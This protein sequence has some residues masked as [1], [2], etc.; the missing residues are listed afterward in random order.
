MQVTLMRIVRSIAIIQEVVFRSSY[1]DPFVP[2]RVM[3]QVER[4]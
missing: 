1:R 3:R 4:L 2:A